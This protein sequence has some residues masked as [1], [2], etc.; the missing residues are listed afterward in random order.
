MCPELDDGEV[1]DPGVGL[2]IEAERCAQRCYAD[3]GLGGRGGCSVT[4]GQ[5]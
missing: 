1:C 5:R 4:V 2:A 3:A